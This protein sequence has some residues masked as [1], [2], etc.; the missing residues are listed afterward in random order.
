MRA[1]Q[2]QSENPPTKGDWEEPAALQRMSLH[3]KF[4]ARSPL[5][6]EILT[7]H[8]N[9]IRTAFTIDDH[10]LFIGRRV[11][12]YGGLGIEKLHVPDHY[13][14]N[15]PFPVS[16]SLFQHRICLLTFGIARLLQGA[17]IANKK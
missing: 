2:E 7:D 17:G 1:S 10:P 9:E 8:S 15:I 3:E 6:G 11:L 16:E 13:I 5:G 14:T 4:A 12:D